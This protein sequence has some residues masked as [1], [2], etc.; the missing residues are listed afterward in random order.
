MDNNILAIF[1]QEGAR[2]FS[3]VIKNRRPEPPVVPAEVSIERFFEDSERR[4]A[5][6]FPS[7]QQ[8]IET[9]EE[10][11]V[12]EAKPK[13]VKQ[14]KPPKQEEE[15]YEEGPSVPIE[16]GKAKTIAT[17]CVP[18]AMGHF[19]TCSGLIN[20]S[21][22]FAHSEDGVASPE[23]IDRVNM[24]MDELNAMER[25]DLRPEMI[26]QLDGWE[27][28]LAE[29]VLTESRA[30]RHLLEGL[31]TPD[32]LQEAAAKIQETRQ[33]IGRKWFQN[34]LKN[35]SSDDQNEISRR[36]MAKIQEMATVDEDEE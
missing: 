23:V 11:K 18:C 22:R 5:P 9:K 3:Q 31:T 29:K 4:M 14:P 27:K 36:V 7:E 34:K 33:E 16:E 21:V 10:L 15:E 19:G 25:V 35:M 32:E 30:T 20:E 2:I 28:E 24:C 13:K 26:V 6:L 12:I 8:E 1:I 17:G